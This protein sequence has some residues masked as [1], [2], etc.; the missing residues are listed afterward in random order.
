M[1]SDAT[2]GIPVNRYMTFGD[3]VVSHID[4][5]AILRNVAQTGVTP[6]AIRLDMGE[7]TERILSAEGP[8]G[9]AI[10]LATTK[11]EQI[12]TKALDN[13]D[14]NHMAYLSYNNH[15]Q[16]EHL[17]ML[18]DRAVQSSDIGLALSLLH[19]RK[20]FGTLLGRCAGLG[21]LVS[22]SCNLEHVQSALGRFMVLA[23][24]EEFELCRKYFAE[25]LD[26]D[27]WAKIVNI[28]LKLVP[29]FPVTVDKYKSLVAHGSLEC[30]PQAY[31]ARWSADCS[32]IYSDFSNKV[33]VS[34]DEELCSYLLGLQPYMKRSLL[35]LIE[36]SPY[37]TY[38]ESFAVLCL[39]RMGLYGLKS[40]GRR[41][42][43]S[44]DTED[45]MP[46]MWSEPTRTWVAK[47]CAQS[48]D[49][50]EEYTVF[51][52]LLPEW[53]GSLHDLLGVCK[54]L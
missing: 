1:S 15:V 27:Q 16:D 43:V 19:G 29:K 37:S 48:F 54:A 36:S 33:A 35:T 18:A 8:K 13:D 20:D 47:H 7:Q 5:L 46:D 41:G 4:N 39:E 51:T 40:G 44:P 42:G 2:F 53:Q 21:D 52:K 32:Q 24:F 23:N 14:N 26:Y 45:A 30:V 49:N 6:W 3:L 25:R 38:E 31:K 12:I 28:T 34:G 17:T 9:A 11:N 10:L 22:V 50:Y